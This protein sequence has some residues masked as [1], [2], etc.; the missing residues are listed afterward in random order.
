MTKE[1]WDTF[2][3]GIVQKKYYTTI[4]E[5]D[6]LVQQAGEQP[7]TL[8]LKEYLFESYKVKRNTEDNPEDLNER[9]VNGKDIISTRLMKKNKRIDDLI[10]IQRE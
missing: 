2:A 9:L 8:K 4:K 7:L 10:A 6:D 5:L 1:K 3:A